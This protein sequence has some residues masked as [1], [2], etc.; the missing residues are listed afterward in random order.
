MMYSCS[1]IGNKVGNG[2]G[3]AM[4]GI[5][6]AASG[7]VNGAA[8]QS[9]SCINMLNGLFFVLPLIMMILLFIDLFFL[10]VEDSNKKWAEEHTQ[11]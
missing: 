10:K 3:S 1:T 5:L 6:L 11:K 7:Y 2:I 8:Q 4:T 9:Q